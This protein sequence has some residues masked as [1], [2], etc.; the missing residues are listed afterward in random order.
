[1]IGCI[2][3]GP[4]GHPKIY[5]NTS[6]S[7]IHDPAVCGYCGLKYVKME[8]VVKEIEEGKDLQQGRD[9][10]LASDLVKYIE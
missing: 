1:M 7:T 2:G 4:L 5:M 3:S 9:F 8:A 6:Y 10:I